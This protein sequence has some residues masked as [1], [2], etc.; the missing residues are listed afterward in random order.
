MK[1]LIAFTAI[2]LACCWGVSQ[3]MVA[4]ERCSYAIEARNAR[5]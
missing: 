5:M 2:A 1:K 4:L 3:L